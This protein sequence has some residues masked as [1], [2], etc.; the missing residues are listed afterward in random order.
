MGASGL[1]LVGATTMVLA[2]RRGRTT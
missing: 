2:R 1:I